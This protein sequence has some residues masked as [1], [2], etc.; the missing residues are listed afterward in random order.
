MKK[1]TAAFASLML[2]FLFITGCSGFERTTLQT[3]SASKVTIDGAHADYESGKLPHTQAVN[4]VITKAI[5]IQ[6]TAVDAMVVYEQMKITG[7]TS[8]LSEQETVVLV[9]LVNLPTIL[10]D[11]KGLY[12]TGGAK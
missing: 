8:A 11:V 7:Q 1:V 10:T 12:S 9:A 6:K 4:D 2:C 3:L 5:A